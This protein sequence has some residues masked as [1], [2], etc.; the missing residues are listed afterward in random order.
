MVIAA[1]AIGA[2][3][4]SGTSSGSSSS[5]APPVL[6]PP[7]P[8]HAQAETVPCTKVLQQLP[9]DLGRLKGRVVH[10]HPDTPFVV[11]WGDPAVVLACGV[12]RP[13][14][15][16]PGSSEQAFNAGDL[17]GP[18]FFVSRSGDADVWTTVDRAAY[19][20]ITVPSKYQGSAVVPPLSRAIGKAL[21]AVCTTN[22]A[23][24]DVD[25]LCTRRK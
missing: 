6:T 4:G 15:L 8:P 12:D 25:K 20:S 9:V 22:S 5:A 19:I 13:K 2:V 24:P 7:A 23:T 18:Y 21:P 10:T 17:A 3:T 11:A 14:A 16:H 1:L